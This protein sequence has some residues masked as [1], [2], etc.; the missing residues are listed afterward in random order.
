MGRASL[1]AVV[2]YADAYGMGPLCSAYMGT[3]AF[4]WD[5]PVVREFIS[6]GLNGFLVD[7]GVP[8]GRFF[9]ILAS[10]LSVPGAFAVSPAALSSR[11]SQ[12]RAQFSAFWGGLLRNL[13]KE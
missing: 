1:T 10:G 5:C 4:A 2:E 9:E 13:F 11:L 6:P 12:R 7:A 3:P 8:M